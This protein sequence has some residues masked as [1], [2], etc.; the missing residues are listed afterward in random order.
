MNSPEDSARLA[1]IYGPMFSDKTDTLIWLLNRRKIAGSKRQLFKHIDSD[2]GE[3]PDVVV[4]RSGRSHPAV[5]IRDSNEALSLADKKTEIVAFDEAQFFG[6]QLAE[7]VVELIHKKGKR[8]I[9]SALPTDFRDEPF[10]AIPLLIAR[11]DIAYQQYAICE[12]KDNPEDELSCGKL[13]TKTQRFLPDGR[14]APWDDPI[15]KVGD[16]GSYQARCSLHHI[17]PGRPY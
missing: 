17:V 3:G 2:R 15:I 4:S 5:S 1:V 7:T 11:A 16:K 8:V 12:Y 13:A 6:E 10:G 9:V 14:P